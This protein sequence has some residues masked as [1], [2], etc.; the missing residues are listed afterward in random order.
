MDS[1]ILIDIWTVESARRHELVERISG[2]LRS[3]FVGRP[4]FVSAQIYE[5]TEGS[6][7]MLFVRA[8]SVEDRQRLTDSPDAQHAYREL[9]AIAKTHANLYQ[10]VEEFGEG[11]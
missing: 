3:Q 5:S 11:V 4:G 2:I 8:S 10:L 1:P 7:V 9:R 6:V